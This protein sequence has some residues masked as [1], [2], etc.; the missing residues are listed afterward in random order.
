ML[1]WLAFRD[2]GKYSAADYAKIASERVSKDREV[3][4]WNPFEQEQKTKR[5]RY[6]VIKL[7]QGV[8]RGLAYLHDHDRLHQSLGP[9][10]VALK[11]TT[12][13]PLILFM[14]FILYLPPIF[15]VFAYDCIVAA[16]FQKEKVLI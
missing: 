1:Q 15:N 10:S 9:F 3:S 2:D 7:L 14:I 13:K 8:M 4:S 6:F 16:Q 12:T 5:R 11:Y